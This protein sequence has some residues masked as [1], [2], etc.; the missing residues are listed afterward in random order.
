MQ[1]SPLILALLGIVA[2]LLFMKV[3]SWVK[4]KY[5]W[6]KASIRVVCVETYGAGEGSLLQICPWVSRGKYLYTIH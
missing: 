5:W 6:D 3:L 1:Q 2:T 4:T